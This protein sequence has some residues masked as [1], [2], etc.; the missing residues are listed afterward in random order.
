MRLHSAS[1]LVNDIFVT[2][3]RLLKFA[4]TITD[5]ANLRVQRSKY[6]NMDHNVSTAATRKASAY[7]TQIFGRHKSH[8]SATICA[9][10][11][12]LPIRGDRY[13]TAFAQLAIHSRRAEIII[14]R[15][16]IVAAAGNVTSYDNARCT[17]N[18]HQHLVGDG[19]EKRPKRVLWFQR[20]ARKPSNRSVIAAIQK[21][22]A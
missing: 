13:T 6:Y 10:V 1:A 9:V 11:L 8:A 12:T 17:M 7:S 22:S 5:Q 4:A 21:I 18:R 19:V 15:A 20:R 2:H 14:S 16:I 3:D